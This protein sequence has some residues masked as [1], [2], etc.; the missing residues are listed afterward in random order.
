V[1]VIESGPQRDELIYQRRLCK[2]NARDP[3]DVHPYYPLVH[4]RPDGQQIR[5][6]SEEYLIVGG[7]PRQ[8]LRQV[9]AYPW[10]TDY[11]E[12]THVRSLI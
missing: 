6:I 8:E 5:F 10:W 3:N 2:G 4:A 7:D 9:F 12:R 1:Y 11:D